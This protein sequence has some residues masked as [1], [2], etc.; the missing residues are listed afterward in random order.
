LFVSVSVIGLVVAVARTSHAQLDTKTEVPANGNVSVH[1]EVICLHSV[2][3]N[4]KGTAPNLELAP[5]GLFGVTPTFIDSLPLSKS[6]GNPY[7]EIGTW[8]TG[9]LSSLSAAYPECW[10]P[11][12]INALFRPH[13]W[14]GLRN[15]DDQ[16]AKFDVKAELFFD[17]TTLGESEVRCV[18]GLTRN[19]AKA[20]E[21]A[22]GPDYG[23]IHIVAN[24]PDLPTDGAIRLKISARMGTDGETPCKGHSSAT[25]VRLY[26][27]S[28]S[29]PSHVLWYLCRPPVDLECLP[30]V[31]D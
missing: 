11:A 9:S 12:V 14:M 31:R 18:D 26:S 23:F 29:R 3:L 20:L 4:L 24:G 28:E 19:P 17:D 7:R 6:G 21:V 1:G 16:G 5:N 25:G 22:V 13:V 8:S 30:P 15:S 10:G 2:S 27:D